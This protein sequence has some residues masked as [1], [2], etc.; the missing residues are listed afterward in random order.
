MRKRADHPYDMIDKSC[1]GEQV[2]TNWYK[3]HV[4]DLYLKIPYLNRIL[5]DYDG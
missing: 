3:N 2:L 4:E 5:G 1:M